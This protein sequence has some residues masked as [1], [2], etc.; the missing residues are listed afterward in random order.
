MAFCAACAQ[1]FRVAAAPGERLFGSSSPHQ[2]L[3]FGKHR[4]EVPLKSGRRTRMV[5]HMTWIESGVV[6][7]VDEELVEH[8]EDIRIKVHAQLFAHRLPGVPK[9]RGTG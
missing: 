1:S 9:R 5:T 3:V 2:L 6:V 4:I 7:P 8:G